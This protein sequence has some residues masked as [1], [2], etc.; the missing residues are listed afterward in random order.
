MTMTQTENKVWHGE[1]LENVE[2]TLSTSIKT[3]LSQEEAKKRLTQYGLNELEERGGKS[4][5]LIIWEQFSNTMVLI[6]IAAAVISGF[7]GKPLETFAI[8]AIVVLFAILGFIQEYRAERAIAAL[9]QFAVPLVR[10]RRNGTI[11]QQSAKELV[12]GDV[13]ILEAGGVIPADLRL[14]E[15]SNLMIQEAALTGESEPI[16]KDIL[17]LS[18]DN[19]PLGDRINMAY[20][21]TTVSYGRGAGIVVE[22][23]MQTQ[24][25]RI[26]TL[27][28][29]VESQET[30]YN[31]NWNRSV[32]C[33]RLL[34]LSLPR[35]SWLLALSRTNLGMICF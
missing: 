21:G 24:L 7:L 29:E 12:P 8:S 30:P 31:A 33:L 13:V 14:C 25:G 22:T 15:S 1:T 20:M 4:P 5:F 34:A 27:I 17:A 28:Q 10:V 6:L 23:G 3:G 2:K 9:K 11:E 35:L 32:H 18:A 26:A 16:D 19:M